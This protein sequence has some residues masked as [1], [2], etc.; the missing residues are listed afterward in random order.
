MWI[1]QLDLQD[2]MLPVS[3]EACS[4]TAPE[5]PWHPWLYPTHHSKLGRVDTV[6]EKRINP[7]RI[8]TL[9]MSLL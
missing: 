2:T 3:A 9:S 4:S 1:F 7:K 5:I 8:K 6:N